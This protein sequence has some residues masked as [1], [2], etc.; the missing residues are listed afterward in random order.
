MRAPTLALTHRYAFF[1]GH[2]RAHTLINSWACNLTKSIDSYWLYS[3]MCA[4]TLKVF[5]SIIRT[6]AHVPKPAWECL[7]TY[8]HTCLHTHPCP[9][10]PGN[11]TVHFLS[12]A[13]RL[14]HG[15]TAPDLVPTRSPLSHSMSAEMRSAFPMAISPWTLGNPSLWR[16][17][18][19][20]SIRA[21]QKEIRLI[22]LLPFPTTSATPPQQK[23]AF[24]SLAGG[25]CGSLLL[26]DC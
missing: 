10:P 21:T 6:W 4:Y 25:L 22:T 14:A 20:P 8:L 1:C 5:M 23:P 11:Q 7:H 17:T 2:A 15:R 12:Q 26:T 3:L 9:T 13:H 18:D 19:V 16:D 24:K